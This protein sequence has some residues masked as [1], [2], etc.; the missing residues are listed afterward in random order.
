M[1]ASVG[2]PNRIPARSI[3][4]CECEYV[5]TNRASRAW[6]KPTGLIEDGNDGNVS[7][8]NYTF[9]T[10]TFWHSADEKLQLMLKFFRTV[11][12]E[13]IDILVGHSAGMYPTLM[14]A[15]YTPIEVKSLVTICGTGTKIL[16]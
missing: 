13:D 3:C 9:R 6:F 2:S 12:I 16:P 15:L 4:L 1:M 14:T 10:E 8:L 5:A 11:D 7:D